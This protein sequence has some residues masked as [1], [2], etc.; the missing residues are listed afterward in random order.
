MESFQKAPKTIFEINIG[1]KVN[2]EWTTFLN[3]IRQLGQ[4]VFGSVYLAE[5]PS[6]GKQYVVKECFTQDKPE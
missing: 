6:N 2:A 5:D 3:K 4:G 1:T